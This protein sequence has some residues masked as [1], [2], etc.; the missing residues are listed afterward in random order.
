VNSRFGR[1]LTLPAK[2]R[3]ASL[4]LSNFEPGVSF[5]RPPIG[6]SEE[7]AEGLSLLELL[8]SRSV[9]KVPEVMCLLSLLAPPADHAR[10]C[11]LPY[12]DFTLRGVRLIGR[13]P[14]A[15]A[16]QSDLLQLPLTV[17][18]HLALKVNPID[19]SLLAPD[20][21]IRAG[22]VTLIGRYLEVIQEGSEPWPCPRTASERSRRQTTRRSAI[23]ICRLALLSRC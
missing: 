22:P 6:G 10:Q 18:E 14:T 17:W 19:F 3:K 2:L 9:L 12:V 11:R 7:C 1:S 15:G 20:A 8:R 13:N 5:A 21:N 23:G 4:E 16:M